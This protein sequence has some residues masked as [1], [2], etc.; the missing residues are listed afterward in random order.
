MSV[1]G[2]L[3]GIVTPIHE[4]AESFWKEKGLDVSAEQMAR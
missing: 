4:G 3:G 2:A 1:E